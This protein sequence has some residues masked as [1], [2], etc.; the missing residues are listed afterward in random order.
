[1]TNCSVN[2]RANYLDPPVKLIEPSPIVSRANGLWLALKVWAGRQ[3]ILLLTVALPMVAAVLYYGFIASDVYVSESRFVVRSPKEQMQLGSVAGLLESSGLSHAQDDAYAVHDFIQSRD[4]LRELDEKLALR[5]DFTSR[6]IDI[7]DRFPGLDWD[8]SFESLYRYYVKHIVNV[9]YDSS[10][11]ISTLT[12]YA[13]DPKTAHQINDELLTMAE[14][15]VNRMNERSHHDLVDI[16]AREVQQAEARATAATLALSAFR[17]KQGVYEPNKQSELQL[18]VAAR[19]EGELV[20]LEAEIAQMRKLSPENP[21]L[22]G[23]LSQAQAIEHAITEQ[24]ARVA[25]G[26]DSFSSRSSYFERLILE[27]GFAEKE[28]E[29]A[30]VAL[31]TA[32]SEAR[33]QEL[34]LDRLVEPSDP[35]YPTEPHRLRSI[36]TVGAFGLLLWGIVSL[37]VASVREHLD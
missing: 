34:Y 31:E 19:L 4:A 27:R 15:L 35:D 20:A 22:V 17:N 26:R 10:T 18:E 33:R 1:M 8:A 32:R 2:E 28:L 24:T 36:V 21:A 30:N 13:F 37:I 9:D 5:R 11:S 3:L 7:F 25:G 12:T 6:N 16:A 14:R 23:L 29:A